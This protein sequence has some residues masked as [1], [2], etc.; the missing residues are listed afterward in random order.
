MK[1]IVLIL[2]CLGAF[3]VPGI[4]QTASEEVQAEFSYRGEPIHP[5]ILKEFSNW[6]SD[7]RPPMITSVDLA[8]AFNS[9]R[10]QNSEVEKRGDWWF[11]EAGEM[12]SYESFGYRWL[13]KLESGVHVLETGSSGGGSGFF[14][15]LMFIQFSEGEIFWENKKEKQLLMSI[16]GTYSLGDRYEG[17]IQ[18]RGDKIF[19]PA[20]AVQQ[21]GGAN[22]KDIVLTV[23]RVDRTA[24]NG[25][26]L[27]LTE[28]IKGS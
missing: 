6:L 19:I 12:D 10:Y 16:V 3:A 8:A 18:I 20:S 2:L 17:D 11:A 7:N 13:G 26:T 15:D 24:S 5:F 27:G 9:N 28:K 14:M 25:D 23:D 4:S 1:K 21:G 22:E